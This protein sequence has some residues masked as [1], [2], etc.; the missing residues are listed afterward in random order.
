M[1]AAESDIM[2]PATVLLLSVVPTVL[3]EVYEVKLKPPGMQAS[4][5]FSTA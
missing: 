2:A 3:T 1:Q 4:A 5:G